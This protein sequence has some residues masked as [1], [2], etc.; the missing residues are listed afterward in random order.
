MVHFEPGRLTL[1][2]VIMPLKSILVGLH[3]LTLHQILV[4]RL[5]RTEEQ[6]QSGLSKKVASFV[7]SRSVRPLLFGL[8][9]HD[10]E[11]FWRVFIFA[12]VASF[13]ISRS[14]RPLFFGGTMVNRFSRVF[15]FVLVY[16]LDSA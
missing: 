5:A 3:S 1:E 4:C 15:V 8:G 13:V 2:F 6:L 12:P 10:G 14:A 9:F 11:V 16:L 7:S